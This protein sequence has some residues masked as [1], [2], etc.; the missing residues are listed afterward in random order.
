MSASTPMVARAT[1]QRRMNHSTASETS[2]AV[3]AA[4][5][6]HRLLLILVA[7]RSVDHGLGHQRDRDGGDQAEQRR[8]RASRSS[9]PGRAS[10]TAA[11]EGCP[12]TTG[13]AEVAARW[14]ARSAAPSS[15]MSRH[16]RLPGRAT[17]L[18]CGARLV[19]ELRLVQLGVAPAPG[20]QLA[21]GCRVRRCGR[22]RRRGS[23][24]PP[25][26]S[27]T[28]ARSRSTSGPPAPRRA[29]AAPRPRTPSPAT[30]SPRRARRPASVPSS[31]RAMVNRCRC[32]PE[33]R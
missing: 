9:A 15:A 26:S 28:G 25:G 13:S 8:D 5:S 6:T 16:A 11:A 12:T 14:P 21:R 7:H 30:R 1:S 18:S 3:A 33:S 17:D 20:Q 23:G 19:A 4:P 27:T 2:T 10:G 22:P 29:P 24:R 32:P 31:S